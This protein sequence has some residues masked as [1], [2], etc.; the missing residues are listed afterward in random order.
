[1]A[2]I[3]PLPQHPR[4][5]N[6]VAP[7]C[8][9]PNVSYI[10][11]W[12]VF[13]AIPFLVAVCFLLIHG[14]LLAYKRYFLQQRSWEVVLSHVDVLVSS[15]LTLFFFLFLQLLRMQLEVFD[16]GPLNPPDGN[17]YLLVVFEKC[18]IPGGVQMTLLPWA[19]ITLLG[20]SVA[21]PAF[22]SWL[23]WKNHERIMEDQLLRA[24]GG[25]DDR[26]TNPN[27]YHL[28]RRY[29]RT[30]YQVIYGVL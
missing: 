11:K 9:V 21:Y 12:S 8:L 14:I 18:G 26:L 15:F 1:M 28:R 22:L 5:V 17:L 25:G 13:E 29:A 6:I 2:D 16:C 23:Y 7:E 10:Q 20:Y 24:K 4:T 30:Y 27:A 19:I 3:E